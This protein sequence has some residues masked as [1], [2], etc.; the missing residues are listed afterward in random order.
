[1]DI[2]TTVC[3]DKTQPQL[4]TLRHRIRL[5]VS[6]IELGLTCS[7]LDHRLEELKLPFIVFERIIQRRPVLATASHA[8]SKLEKCFLQVGVISASEVITCGTTLNIPS[9]WGNEDVCCLMQHLIENQVAFSVDANG[10]I[11]LNK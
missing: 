11:S 7:K 5:L 1:M 3:E 8:A 2:N 9:Y 6:A 4:P 10:Q